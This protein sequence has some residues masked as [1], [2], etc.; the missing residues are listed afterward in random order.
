MYLNQ[1]F[2]DEDLNRCFNRPGSNTYESKRAKILTSIIKQYDIVYDIHETSYQMKTCIFVNEINEEVKK[3]IEPVKS[4]YVTLDDHPDYSGHFT[5]SVAKVGITLEYRRW[6][7]D[8]L[9]QDFFN[10]INNKLVNQEKIFMR[11]YKAIPAEK[12][13]FKLKLK[14]FQQLTKLQKEVLEIKEEGIFYPIFV[15]SRSYKFYSFINKKI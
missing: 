14:N 10:I 8:E 9:K 4:I 3:A 5:T 15:N 12:K 7:K 2:I 6:A 1:R 13:Y 11:I